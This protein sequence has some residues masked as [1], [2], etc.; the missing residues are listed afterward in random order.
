M[1]AHPDVESSAPEDSPMALSAPAD[2]ARRAD[3]VPKQVVSFVR[4]SPRMN[5]SQRAAL[6]YGMEHVV[7]DVPADERETTIAPDFTLDLSAAFGQ[8]VGG[9][10]PDAR[11][12]IVE[13]GCGVGDSLAPMAK[14]R[15]TACVLAFEV[16][17]RGVAST[18]SKLR[19]LEVD[20]VR[21]V[22]ADGV[23]G[24]EQLIPEGSVSELWT[25]FPDPW[26]KKRHHKRRLI[27]SAFADLV[28]SRLAPGGL[29]WLATDW[30]EYASQMREV[31]D[32]APGLE[33]VGELPD[34]W[35]Q[36][37]DRPVT[38][39]ER[40]GIQAGRQIHDLRYRKLA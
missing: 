31:L 28:T 36:R 11:R 18:C 38:R 13:I 16:Y 26:Q 15:P 39:F 2:S 9:A 35:A 1:P 40:R 4:R 34:G 3:Y 27:S 33:N 8:P 5:P 19:A 6:D 22:M 7:L 30:D 25:F 17:Q 14:A 37:L 24:L 32:A 12:L 10:E 29:W 23:A 21:L 20:N